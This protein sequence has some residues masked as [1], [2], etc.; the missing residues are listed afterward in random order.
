MNENT[1]QFGV[2]TVFESFVSHVSHWRF[3]SSKRKQ[4]KDAIGKP[5]EEKGSLNNV[6]ESMSTE[7][8]RNSIS[9]SLKS[10]QKF[11]S[12][13]SDLREHLQRRAQQAVF[14]ENSIQGKLSLDEYDAEI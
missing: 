6:A 12:D 3:C 9:V 11:H 8:R 5:R 13:G 10:L 1:S 7:S 4:K 14:A 2:S